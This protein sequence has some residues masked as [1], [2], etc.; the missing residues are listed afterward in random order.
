MINNEIN[1]FYIFILY[2]E[3][4]FKF[5][6]WFGNFIESIEFAMNFRTFEL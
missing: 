5:H 3:F 2:N 4:E 6:N 1:L